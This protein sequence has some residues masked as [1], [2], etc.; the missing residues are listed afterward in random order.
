MR[1]VSGLPKLLSI[2]SRKAERKVL[3][4]LTKYQIACAIFHWYSGP[5]S[6]VSE[7]VAAGYY[8]SINPAMV[9]SE[10]GRKVIKQIPKDRLLTE[11][12]GPFTKVAGRITM[13]Q[14]VSYVYSKLG[15]ILQ[16]PPRQVEELVSS[17]FKRLLVTRD[18]ERYPLN[19]TTW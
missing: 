19:N 2:H 11:T 1:E 10:S 16:I 12:D 17:N 9:I 5:V 6:L 7:I 8:F 18:H 15:A 13:P 4:L 3:S 14:D